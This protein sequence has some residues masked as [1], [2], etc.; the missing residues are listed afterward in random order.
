M[1]TKYNASEAIKP[2]GHKRRCPLCDL[3]NKKIYGNCTYCNADLGGVYQKQQA[4]AAK[5]GSRPLFIFVL[6]FIIIIFLIVYNLL[7]HWSII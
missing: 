5:I 6:L 1:K 2:I 3:E 4:A 7:K